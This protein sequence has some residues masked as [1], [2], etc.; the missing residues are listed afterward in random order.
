MQDF[1]SSHSKNFTR[2]HKLFKLCINDYFRGADSK[3]HGVG[4]VWTFDFK[5]KGVMEVKKKED[6]FLPYSTDGNTE[7]RDGGISISKKHF[8]NIFKA[9]DANKII[10]K[11][12]VSQQHD[13]MKS[14]KGNLEFAN[15]P[16]IELFF[17]VVFN[18]RSGVRIEAEGKDLGFAEIS[19]TAAARE[20]SQHLTMADYKKSMKFN[21]VVSDLGT[22]DPNIGVILT[23]RNLCLNRHL[24]CWPML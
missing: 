19:E 2:L 17:E 3:S 4:K 18:Y 15:G 14:D 12:M 7:P 11:L 8:I 6:T 22:K 5:R 9:Q 13:L 24:L 21:L 10:H 16:D 1:I 23:F 20:K